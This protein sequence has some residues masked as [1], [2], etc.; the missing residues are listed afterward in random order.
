MI[1]AILDTNVFI[2]AALGSASPSARVLDAY[3]DSK[4][5][6]VLS[7]AVLEELFGVLILPSIR[8]HQGWSD[9]EIIDFLTKLPA[10]A[11]MYAGKIHVP[12]SIPRDVTDTKFLSL[13]HES[14]ADYPVTKDG[15]HL[16][17]LGNYRRTRIVT[18]H[19]FL[20]VLPK[21]H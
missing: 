17:R 6:L 11:D 3:L 8:A 15:R 5:Q 2:R 16:L 10:A 1:S 18:P 19:E 12:A 13:A 21:V 9:D 14:D 20:R 4:F 7:P